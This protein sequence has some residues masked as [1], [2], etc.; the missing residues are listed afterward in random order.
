MYTFNIEVIDW[1]YYI[2]AKINGSA[3]R[4]IV[5]SSNTVNYNLERLV[6]HKLISTYKHDFLDFEVLI[7]VLIS[8]YFFNVHKVLLRKRI[9]FLRYTQWF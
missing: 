9:S 4:N 3:K 2:N 5:V 6:S 7:L 8:C 1:I